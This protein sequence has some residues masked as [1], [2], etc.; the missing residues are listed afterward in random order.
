MKRALWIVLPMLFG[1]D[2]RLQVDCQELR[3]NDNGLTVYKYRVF[4][5]TCVSYHPNGNVYE[6]IRWQ[7]GVQNGVRAEYYPDG[8]LKAKYPV[9][10]GLANGKYQ[11]YHPN[12]QL[13][14]EGT[15]QAG[16]K[17]G[18]WKRWNEQGKLTEVAYWNNGT[19]TDIEE[20]T[21]AGI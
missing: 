20:F 4:S 19:L 12:E 14:Y 15:I 2:S 6:L 10:N 1:C 5:G 11:S 7:E 17:D 16:E 9:E 13:E 21:S 3:V 8:T 18:E